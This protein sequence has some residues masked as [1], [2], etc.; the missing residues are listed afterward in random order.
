MAIE[1]SGPTPFGQ[2]LRRLRVAAGL[3]QQALAQRSRL[4]EDAISAYENGRRRCPHSDTLEMLAD[5]LG[6]GQDERRALAA[7]A[8]SEGR[9]RD[10]RR[11]GRL[12]EH[13]AVFLSHTADLREH[14]AGRSFVAAAEA[15]VTRA[16]HAVTDMA[17]FAA[18]D[19]APSDYCTAMVAKAD[20]YVGIIGL[21]Y[22]M[23]VRG[24]QQQSYTEL[25]FETATDSKLP[26]LVFLIRE[27]ATSLP[28]ARQSA[29]H[30]ARQEAFRHR[31]QEAGTTFVWISTPAELEIELFH[32]LIELRM[33]G[34]VPR[35]SHPG[36]R[37]VAQPVWRAPVPARSRRRGWLP[38]LALATAVLFGL[39]ASVVAPRLPG[40]GLPL[41][42]LPVDVGTV[43]FLG[44]QAQPTAEYL[45]MKAVLSRFKNGSVD[46]DSQ[47][48]AATDIQTILDGQKAGVSAIDLTDLTHSEMLALQARG[49]L[50]DLTPL[51][52]RLQRDR[53]F[54]ET[55]LSYGR[56]GT[57]K[58]YYIPWLQ[59][60]YM[61]VISKKALP[62]RPAGIDV[63]HLTY[64]QLIAWGENI[65]TRTRHNRIGLPA[66]LGSPRGGLIYRFLQGY[67]YPSFTGTT[68]TG[69]R[70][71]EAVQMWGTLRRL[72]SVVD[73]SSTTYVNMQDPLETGE[74]WIAW[75]H[76]ARLKGALADP[77]NFL[78]VPA[79]S[80]PKGLGYMTA[81]V[82]LAIPKGSSNLV[83]AEALIDWLT[84][85]TQQAAVSTSLSFLPVVEGVSPSGPEAV[86][87]RVEG[88]YRRSA[89]GR[90]TMPPAGLGV[91][92]N[93]FTTTYQD[94]F[95]R[96]VLKNEDV[97]AVLDDEAQRLQGVVDAAQARCWSPDTWSSGAC[98][99]A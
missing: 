82:G 87:S 97:R 19:S 33:A 55:L 32:A 52:Q 67:A 83:G 31:L 86:E 91:Y 85:P 72:W 58:Q 21:R 45:A 8:R 10:G 7:T 43:R 37:T 40:A 60:T 84:R 17:Y 61:M 46:F 1:G 70:S 75:D 64:D 65:R 13:A 99:I 12:P 59:A 88:M 23:P 50:E 14:P 16:G 20:V 76:Q 49:A 11:A 96:I 51:L 57:S 29:E 71:P 41:A 92:S 48:T 15:A 56:F 4:S 44:S 22:G 26:R 34:W 54:P 77:D 63:N 68:L 62:Y 73:Q 42:S 98:H 6:L 5:G 90:E 39:G 69:F 47:P 3:T 95:D 9:P 28:P 53:Q 80:G 78:A 25:E 2:E 24:R 74:I 35:A 27:D 30:R 79:P 36:P 81:L 93:D 18:Q 94:T 89:I 38:R 66:Q